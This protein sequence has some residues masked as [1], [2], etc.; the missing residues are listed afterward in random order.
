MGAPPVAPAPLDAVPPAPP[1]APPEGGDVLPFEKKEKSEKKD[2][3]DDKEEDK[4]ASIAAQPVN[5]DDPVFLAKFAEADTWGR[6][7]AREHIKEAGVT[8]WVKK[9]I[10]EAGKHYKD[11]KSS[12]SVGQ[13]VKNRALLEGEK[14]VEVGKHSLKDKAGWAARAAGKAAKDNPGH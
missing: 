11:L 10:E 12:A 2:K 3:D 8:D 6:E 13:A 1:E 4:E 9:P 5:F 7:L 14:A